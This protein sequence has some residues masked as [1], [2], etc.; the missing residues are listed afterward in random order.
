VRVTLPF[1]CGLGFFDFDVSHEGERPMAIRWRLQRRFRG[2]LSAAGAVAC[3]G[4]ELGY[5]PAAASPVRM[6]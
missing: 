1:F 3:K 5:F 4:S 6:E 2:L